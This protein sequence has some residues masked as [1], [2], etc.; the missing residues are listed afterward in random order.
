MNFFYCW[1]RPGKLRHG[2]RQCRHCQVAI[3]ECGCLSYG[4]TPG[5]DCPCCEGSGWVGVVRSKAAMVE[6]A[7]GLA[8][9][10]MGAR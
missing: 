8:D 4:R 1:H 9:S 5:K 2:L 10:R 3:E 7:L 6:Q